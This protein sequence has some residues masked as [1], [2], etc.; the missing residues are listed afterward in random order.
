MDGS[1]GWFSAPLSRRFLPSLQV[2]DM[3][4][5]LGV[6]GTGLRIA[7][8]AVADVRVARVLL[9]QRQLYLPDLAVAVDS[10]SVTLCRTTDIALG[11]N[12][13]INSLYACK[14]E[15]LHLDF[16]KV[17]LLKKWKHIFRK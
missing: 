10:F 14:M 15:M 5:D 17:C 13:P 16:E 2:D 7:E 3:E 11:V 9:V 1:I 6:G 12:R 4:R 8:G